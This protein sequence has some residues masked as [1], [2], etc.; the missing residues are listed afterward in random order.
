MNLIRFLNGF[1]GD[2]DRGDAETFAMACDHAEGAIRAGVHLSLAEYRA[3]TA[4][5]RAAW[6]VAGNRVLRDGTRH[7]AP[8]TTIPTSVEDWADQL[9]ETIF[10]ASA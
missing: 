5:L 1:S 6:I 4:E 3:M 8:G 2:E 7:V 10:G 9:A